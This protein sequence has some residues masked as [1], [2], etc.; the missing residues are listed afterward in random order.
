MILI[1]DSGVGK[2]NLILRYTKNEFD[3][4]SQSTI[5]VDFSS[6]S[7][8]NKYMIIFILIFNYLKEQKK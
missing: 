5:G 4:T 7:V 6:R 8:I 1:G 2:S 3:Y